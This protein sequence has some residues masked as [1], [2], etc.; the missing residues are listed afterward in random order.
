MYLI[1]DIHSHGVV[2]GIQEEKSE[3]VLRPVFGS[4]NV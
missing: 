4:E 1:L 2:V 3:K